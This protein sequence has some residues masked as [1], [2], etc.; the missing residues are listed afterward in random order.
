M[1]RLFLL[2]NKAILHMMRVMYRCMRARMCGCRAGLQMHN[3]A[4]Q[5]VQFGIQQSQLMIIDQLVG[6]ILH[7]KVLH[8][9]NQAYPLACH[10]IVALFEQR[11]RLARLQMI[12]EK[13]TLWWFSIASRIWTQ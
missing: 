11:N 7:R 1:K 10:Q 13:K 12:Q 3:R 9:Q 6:I 8:L 2:H 5:P 4:C